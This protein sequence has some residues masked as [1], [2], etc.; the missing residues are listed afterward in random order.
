[1]DGERSTFSTFGT[2]GLRQFGVRQFRPFGLRQFRPSAVSAFGS[3]G[4]RHF[5]SRPH[6]E[7]QNEKSE[8][9]NPPLSLFSFVI[10]GTYGVGVTFPFLAATSPNGIGIATCSGSFE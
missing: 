4:V 6:V 1:M 9:S 3:L 7:P 8:S 5:S 10:P 2:F